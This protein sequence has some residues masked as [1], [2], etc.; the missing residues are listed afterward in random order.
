MNNFNKYGFLE[1][2]K[3]D[4]LNDVKNGYLKSEDEIFDFINSYLDNMVIYYSDCFA[5]CK[6]LGFTD[7]TGHELG[8]INNICQ[9]AY[10]A[11]YDFTNEEFNYSEIEE[12]IKQKEEEEI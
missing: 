8:E 5:I 7:F 12:A 1:D 3:K 11:L 10:C 2:L 9:A 4:L 6:A